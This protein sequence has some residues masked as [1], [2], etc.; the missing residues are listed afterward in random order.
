MTTDPPSLAQQIRDLVAGVRAGSTPI[1][2]AIRGISPASVGHFLHAGFD[3][4]SGDQQ[5]LT[6]GL[7]ASPGAASGRVVFTADDAITASDD[8]QSVILVRPETTPDDV[9]GM[10]SSRGIL[11]ARG[12]M[13]SHAAVVARGWGIPAV[14]GAG[15]LVIDD[16]GARIGD[17]ELTADTYLSIDG[18]TGEVF[19]GAADINTEEAPPELD[20]LLRWADAVNANSYR[21]VHIRANADTATD[22]A[23]ARRLGAQGIGLCRTEHMFLAAD[24]L[25][26]VRAF[27]LTD[28]PEVERRALADLE[29]AQQA[30]F[31]ALLEVMDG[32]P[33]TVRLLDPPLHEF[34]PDR[35]H[36]VVAEAL[37][38]LDEHGQAELAA[39]R[40]LHEANPMIGTRGV[41]LGVVRPGLYEMQCRA[42]FRAVLTMIGDGRTPMV[43]V[44]IPLIVD[45][46]EMA[47][48]RRWVIEAA[49]EVGLD[50]DMPIGAMVETPRAAMVAGELSEVADFM[51][52]GTNDLTQLTF[53]FSRDDVGS[54]M[55][56]AYLEAGLLAADPF[57]T[58]DATGVGR[59]VAY[60]C[61]HAR[62]AR[63]DL[64]MGVC[65][66]QGGDPASADFFISC[67]VDY[68]SCS[69]YRVPVARLAV[70]QAV[71]AAGRLGEETQAQLTTLVAD[72]VW[73]GGPATSASQPAPAATSD[74]PSAEPEELAP[75]D[76]E[77]E[78]RFNVLH[79]VRIKG[80]G[81]VDVLAEIA[82]LSEQRTQTVLQALTDEG[83]CMF[84]EKRS[85]WSL[86]PAGRAAHGEL[87][88]HRSIVAREPLGHPYEQFLQ[89]NTAFKELCNSWQL[90]NGEM[91]DHSDAGYDAAR[92]AELRT[93]DEQAEPLLFQFGEVMPRLAAYRRRLSAALRRTEDGETR[94][95]T[96]VMCN[97]YHDVW[98][99]LH[100]DLIQLLG[101]DRTAEGSF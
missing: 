68:L 26:L 72:P 51:S 65:G 14:V 97:S 74:E 11:T 84:L 31:E 70:A 6:T 33:V 20:V 59:M 69:P 39:V 90:R 30:D 63:A 88:V 1:A 89:I 24:R 25:P 94:M 22:A 99:E 62:A 21:P 85:M 37:G 40:R 29:A 54:K 87:S 93:L 91:N 71:L 76:D 60:A 32:L 19:L 47:L 35:E 86:T 92:V 42:L 56:P 4:S 28:D 2:D 77:D 9:L 55:L 101:V 34:L 43:E 73:T 75:L 80:F 57:Q 81:K 46:A 45:P 53:G 15:E 17:V 100:E 58:V 61:D 18:T 3:N 82:D 48:A 96:G 49:R 66:E 13:A 36:L 38:Q 8:G 44:M 16:D 64:K 79:A 67:G 12:G 52:F 23:H 27:I 78:D 98:M 5:L 7:G 41:R 83:L 95:F 10:Q 50:D